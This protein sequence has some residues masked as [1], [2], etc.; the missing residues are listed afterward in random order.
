VKR[1]IPFQELT[2]GRKIINKKNKKGATLRRGV[3][4]RE[5]DQGKGFNITWGEVVADRF[6]R[7][8]NVQQSQSA[9]TGPISIEY[10]DSI[11]LITS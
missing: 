4:Q 6:R 11:T 5:Q 3:R 8:T 7:H 10:F 9:V 1:S 2:P